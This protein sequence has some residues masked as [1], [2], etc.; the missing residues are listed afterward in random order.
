MPKIFTNYLFQRLH[1]QNLFYR[2]IDMVYRACK[3]AAD[4]EDE[5]SAGGAAF[6]YLCRLAPEAFDALRTRACSHEDFNDRFDNTAVGDDDLAIVAIRAMS[7]EVPEYDVT[8]WSSVLDRLQN[9]A[10][11]Q[12]LESQLVRRLERRVLEY[13]RSLRLQTPATDAEWRGLL[14]QQIPRAIEVARDVDAAHAER[15]NRYCRAIWRSM[16]HLHGS[17]GMGVLRPGMTSPTVPNDCS[18]EAAAIHSQQVPLPQGVSNR[19][20]IN[21]TPLSQLKLPLGFLL[22]GQEYKDR[23]G[24]SDGPRDGPVPISTSVI[25]VNGY[26]ERSGCVGGVFDGCVTAEGHGQ[27]RNHQILVYLHAVLVALDLDV[28]GTRII[29]RNREGTVRFSGG[30]GELKPNQMLEKTPELP[31]FLAPF[32]NGAADRYQRRGRWGGGCRN[33]QCET[34]NGPVAFQSASHWPGVGNL[35]TDASG[36]RHYRTPIAVLRYQD[37]AGTSVTREGQMELS[38]EG[39]QGNELYRFVA[40]VQFLCNTVLKHQSPPV[41]REKV[42]SL[43]LSQ[44]SP[45]GLTMDECNALRQLHGS[46]ETA[47]NGIVPVIASNHP[48]EINVFEM[49]PSRLGQAGVFS[50]PRLNLGP[51]MFVEGTLCCYGVPLST[52]ETNDFQTMVDLASHAH[53]TA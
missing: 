42:L 45:Q 25:E 23:A 5:Y 43:A 37:T 12:Q 22:A 32:F 33:L 29:R 52:D 9:E 48:R 38:L 31:R 49:R 53:Y 2:A 21:D 24:D 18:L 20:T 13:D 47:N 35:V 14:D 15:Y 16:T 39:F 3:R 19:R 27:T 10:V 11:R 7:A 44:S 26:D 36:N 4:A 46:G 50:V 51:S 41:L 17:C 1:N 8:D 6:D 34:R 40:A 30:V 28:D